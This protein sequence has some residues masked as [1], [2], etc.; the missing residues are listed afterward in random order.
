VRPVEGEEGGRHEGEF[1]RQVNCAQKMTYQG[2]PRVIPIKPRKVKS[3][4][5]LL[6]GKRRRKN[7]LQ[8][9]KERGLDFPRKKEN[10][11]CGTKLGHQPHFI[12]G[13]GGRVTHSL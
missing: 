9:G 8:I 7:N 3:I 5:V 12:C 2:K 11:T 13:A 1:L 4:Q 6:C 10:F